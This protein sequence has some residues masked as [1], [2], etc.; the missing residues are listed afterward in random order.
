MTLL[1]LPILP[2]PAS[3]FVNKTGGSMQTTPNMPRDLATQELTAEVRALIGEI[4]DE[5][6]K[7]VEFWQAHYDQTDTEEP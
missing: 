5:E 4:Q 3:L 2:A 6:E 7:M 1:P